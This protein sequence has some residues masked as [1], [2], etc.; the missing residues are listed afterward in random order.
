MDYSIVRIYQYRIAGSN[1]RRQYRHS[2]V[3]DSP[4]WIFA[5]TRRQFP[6]GPHAH[7]ASV[8]THMRMI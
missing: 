4:D 8:G 6:S 2:S 3:A 1:S 7:T 5:S